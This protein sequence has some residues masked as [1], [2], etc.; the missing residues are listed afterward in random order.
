VQPIDDWNR[1]LKLA[2]LFECTVGPGRLMVTSFHLTEAEAAKHAGGPSLRRSIL[3][4]MASPEFQPR[5]ELGMA[6][7]DAWM[8]ARYTAPATVLTP[9][10]ST[11][12]ADPGQV[13]GRGR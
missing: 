10:S 1:N 5:T 12:V 9:P 3:E 7:L 11:D 6:A 4:Y 8:P 13:K 2:M